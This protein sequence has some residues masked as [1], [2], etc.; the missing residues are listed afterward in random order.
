MKFYDL[1]WSSLC[2]QYRSAGDK[3]YCE[4]LQDE[5]FLHKIRHAPY[6]ISAK[7]FE[8]KVISNYIEFAMID[9][10]EGFNIA[11]QI[12][13]KIIELQPE[14]SGLEQ[15]DILTCDL[16]DSETRNNIN[17]IYNQLATVENL[18]VTGTSKLLHLINNRLF[19]PLN[20]DILNKL[21]IAVTDHVMID[22]ME[23]LQNEAREVAQDFHAQGLDG[24]PDAFLSDKLGYSKSNCQKS[25][26]KF[27]DEF[28]WM[29]VGDN[30]PVPPAWIPEKPREGALVA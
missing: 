4:M 26:V 28:Y 20:I 2:F 6:E 12:L 19:S 5:K 13:I 24:S 10:P 3:E 8:T 17:K 21:E 14:I 15:H 27:I 18:W 23:V 7:E 16:Q 1:S 29:K 11:L 30:L 9:K 25:L 22:W